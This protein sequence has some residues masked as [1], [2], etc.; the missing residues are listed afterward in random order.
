MKQEMMGGSGISWTICKT[1]APRSMISL[2]QWRKFHQV[3]ST[4]ICIK[5]WLCDQSL[6]H[7]YSLAGKYLCIAV[8]LTLGQWRFYCCLLGRSGPSRVGNWSSQFQQP[9]AA[10]WRTCSS[11]QGIWL[12]LC[13]VDVSA[14]S[15]LQCFD[16]V[17]W[18]ARRASGL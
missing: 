15:C 17:G 1:F 8:R 7:N 2:W 18:A 14:L 6:G 5:M 16:A 4:L 13:A 3:L 11:T 12:F 9:H 10:V